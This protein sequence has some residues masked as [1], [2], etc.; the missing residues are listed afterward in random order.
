MTLHSSGS[1]ADPESRN[2]QAT[3]KSIF[4]RLKT[5]FLRS[6]SLETGTIQGQCV[7]LFLPVPTATNSYLAYWY[8]VC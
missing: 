3:K 1:C 2:Y 8:Q 7:S 6:I 5:D 4:D